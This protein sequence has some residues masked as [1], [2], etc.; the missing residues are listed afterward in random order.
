[1]RPVAK[2]LG[3][4]VIVVAAVAALCYFAPWF[5]KVPDGRLR[6]G[7]IAIIGGLICL[8]IQSAY[9]ADSHE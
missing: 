5:P 9:R 2:F 3:S 4:V 6:Y 7:L 8:G 1:M